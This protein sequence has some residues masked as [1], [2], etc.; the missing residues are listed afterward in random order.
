MESHDYEN[1]DFVPYIVLDGTN[2]TSQIH[3]GEFFGGVRTIFHY[4][5]STNCISL[6]GGQYKVSDKLNIL[7]D[8][9]I[10]S[11]NQV[12]VIL[13]DDTSFIGK[14][15][16][17][18]NGVF[19]LTK[20]TLMF[21]NTIIVKTESSMG[22]FFKPFLGAQNDI[23]TSD[24]INRT[25]EIE[26]LAGTLSFLCVPGYNNETVNWI[27]TNY[28]EASSSGGIQSGVTASA[29]LFSGDIIVGNGGSSIKPSGFRIASGTFN[30]GSSYI[31]S[32]YAVKQYV[33]RRLSEVIVPG[34]VVTTEASELTSGT[35]LLG[36]GGKA[37]AASTMTIEKVSLSG[38]TTKLPSS[39]MVKKY[40]DGIL[41]EWYNIYNV[42]GTNGVPYTVVENISGTI[43]NNGSKYR[44]VLLKF[45]KQGKK[46]RKW[47]MPMYDYELYNLGNAKTPSDNAIIEPDSVVFGY[48]TQ[49]HLSSVF[50]HKGQ[51]RINL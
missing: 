1:P 31:P 46:G 19:V 26:F 45:R 27:C 29:T 30:E 11:Y 40:V 34:N 50:G 39:S 4:I 32:G 21:Q 9:S 28:P 22:I 51:R 14:T 17:I 42:K 7:P 16:N 44:F 12:T 38:G 5:N 49:P 15:V 33:T 6:G 35:V 48:R 47:G 13:P 20:T 3:N 10:T 36:S 18:H 24:H 2:G 43:I 25:I 8:E 37:V 23:T 41:N